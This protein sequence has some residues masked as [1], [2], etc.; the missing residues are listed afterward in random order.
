MDRTFEER[1]AEI[2]S[3]MI[4][5]CMDYADNRAECIYI[6][7]PRRPLNKLSIFL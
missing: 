6:R 2:Q 7:V 4:L 1:L 5:A 3:K